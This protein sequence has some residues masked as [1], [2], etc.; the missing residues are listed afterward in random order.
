MVGHDVDDYAQPAAAERFGHRAERGLAAEV[1]GDARV[2]H[3]VVSVRGTRRGLQD[4]R[5]VSVRDPERGEVV[6]DGGSISE[7]E[8]RP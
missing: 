1:G 6:R 7:P 8:T 4:R 5:Q 3:D 2:V